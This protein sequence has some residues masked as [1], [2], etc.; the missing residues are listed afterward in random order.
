MYSFALF[1]DALLPLSLD[2]KERGDSP[3]P[4]ESRR[5]LSHILFIKKIKKK[6]L[7]KKKS[8]FDKPP[9]N[10]QLYHFRSAR[11]ARTHKCREVL[12]LKKKGKKKEFII[13]EEQL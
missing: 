1:A 4:L 11:S 3:E 7:F 5:I 2:K 9:Q 6:V 13:H 10:K 8:Q 12:D